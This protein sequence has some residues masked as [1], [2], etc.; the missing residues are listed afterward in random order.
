M[1]RICLIEVFNVIVGDD[2]VVKQTIALIVALFL[3]WGAQAT[4]CNSISQFELVNCA[5]ENVQVSTELLNATY[6]EVKSKI[7]S[8]EVEPLKEA[9]RTWAKFRSESCK[10]AALGEAGGR[11]AV[12]VSM[13]CKEKESRLRAEELKY[14]IGETKAYGFYAYLRISLYRLNINFDQSIDKL[15]A[16]VHNSNDLNW[17]ESVEKICQIGYRLTGRDVRTCYARQ[18][19]YGYG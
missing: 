18:A 8:D 16:E 12:L 2:Q 13:A 4:Q 17:Q 7:P 10:K 1:R 5:G 3:P 11:E 9:Q 19:F 6:N 14:L 15:V